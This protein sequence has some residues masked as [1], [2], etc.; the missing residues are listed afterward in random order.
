MKAGGLGY[1][2]GKT[3][4]YSRRFGWPVNMVINQG[5]DSI[6]LQLP[7][8]CTNH[9]EIKGKVE[10]MK[11]ML[12]RYDDPNEKP[13]HSRVIKESKQYNELHDELEALLASANLTYRLSA[14]RIEAESPRDCKVSLNEAS[15]SKR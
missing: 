7:R 13:G 10:K 5:L 2:I 8:G 3:R 11:A 1:E 9:K 6:L 15:L 14:D 4:L 12:A